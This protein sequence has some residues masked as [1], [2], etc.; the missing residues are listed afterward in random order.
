MSD[1]NIA[2]TVIER[3][4]LAKNLSAVIHVA[5]IPISEINLQPSDARFDFRQLVANIMGVPA[6]AT[7][8]GAGYADSLIQLSDRMH[9][10]FKKAEIFEHFLLRV[11]NPTLSGNAWDIPFYYERHVLVETAKSLGMSMESLALSLWVYSASRG[12]RDWRTEEFIETINSYEIPIGQSPE[13]E[14]SLLRRLIENSEAIVLAPILAAGSIAAGQLHQSNCVAAIQTAAAGGA[15][16]LLLVGAS[17]LTR[18]LMSYM[19]H[20]R[21]LYDQDGQDPGRKSRSKKAKT[22]VSGKRGRKI[23]LEDEYGGRKMELED[24]KPKKDKPK[25]SKPTKEKKRRKK[26]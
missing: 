14:G 9:S 8:D 5:S 19:A 15:A 18:Y 23:R 13:V 17:S 6:E 11:A 2:A 21:S 25:K 26:R 7:I 10:P 20:R 22:A 24:E 1:S 12:Y 4:F 16:T 3:C